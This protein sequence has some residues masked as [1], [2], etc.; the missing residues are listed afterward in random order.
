[1]TSAGW[2]WLLVDGLVSGVAP[3]Q[4]QGWLYLR[5]FIPS[6]GMQVFGEQVSNHSKSGFN[7][8]V[9]PDKVDLTYSAA[10]HDAIMLFAHAATK[11]LS[12]TNLTT[13]KYGQTMT[14]AVRSTTFEGVGGNVVA[15]DRHGDRIQSFEVFSYVGASNSGAAGYR[16]QTFLQGGA[17]GFKLQEYKRGYKYCSNYAQVAYTT[18]GSAD[19]CK[20]CVSGAGV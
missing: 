3:E 19:S 16:A 11:V 20:K 10:L 9:S 15:L 12:D 6:E 8:T 7:I 17:A 5:P 2:A 13:R 4:M 1:M 18:E 14:A